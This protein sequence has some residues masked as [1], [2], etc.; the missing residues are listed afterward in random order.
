MLWVEILNRS[1][2]WDA[3]EAIAPGEKEAGG[4]SARAQLERDFAILRWSFASRTLRL[5]VP[6]RMQ[7]DLQTWLE[8][9]TLVP[10]DVARWQGFALPA[11]RAS[12]RRSTLRAS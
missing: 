12:R 10:G 3:G 8:A 6:P 11:L 5:A 1:S 7:A 4:Q 2:T 9:I